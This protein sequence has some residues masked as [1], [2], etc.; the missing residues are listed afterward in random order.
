MSKIKNSHS[1][2]VFLVVDYVF[3]VFLLIV[4]L[5]PLIFIVSSSFSSTKAVTEGRVILFPVD[6]S[7]AGYKA[8]LEQ[9]DIFVGFKNSFIYMFFGTMVNVA[10]TLCAAYPL[11]RNDTPLRNLFMYLFTFTM[12]F[13]GGLIPTYM[14]IKNLGLIDSRLA[15]ILPGAISVWN[16]IITRTF[17]QN[18]IP[19]ELL[20][21]SQ[22]DGCGEARYFTAILL[23]LSKPVIA[24][25]SL[26]YAVGHWN[27]YFNALIYINNRALYPLQIFLREVLI[28][29]SIDLETI[30]DEEMAEA[31]Q[32]LSDLLKYSLVVV[33][34]FPM[35]VLYP[36][37]QKFFI[38]GV[39]IGSI[40]G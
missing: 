5:Y 22:I 11:S 10:L 16:L 38:K 7:L 31:R 39:M 3:V 29:N 9:H 30:Y 15:L 13:S 18:S 14:T 40:K 28:L 26:Y 36:F 2:R 19:R 23:P 25:I 32:G 4:V 37:V 12:F 27:Q 21:V 6:C 35:M 34:V 20:E 1:D 17:I 24:V 33:S 8:V